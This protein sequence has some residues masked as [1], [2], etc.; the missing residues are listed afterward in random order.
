MKIHLCLRIVIVAF[1]LALAPLVS[2]ADTFFSDNFSN[3]STVNQPYFA[4]TTNSASYQTAGG[5]NLGAYSIS[6]G[7][8]SYSLT[9]NGSVL[10]EVMGMFAGTTTP[11]VLATNGDNI[12]LTVVFT[13]AQNIIGPTNSTSSTLNIGLY[14]TGTNTP[15]QGNTILNIDVKSGG[16][17]FW[18]GY[19]T[20]IFQSSGS[21]GIYTRAA[22]IVGAAAQ[23]Q[24]LLFNNAS[25]SQA[26]NNPTG[27][28]VGTTTGGTILTNGQVYTETLSIMLNAAN[29]YGVTNT[30]YA[31]AGT[32]GTVLFTQGKT[33][34]GS[35][36]VTGGFNAM[37]IGWRN[38]ATAAQ[39]ST[40]DIHSITVTGQGSQ[41]NGPPLITSQP[42]SATVATNGTCPFMVT[43]IGLSPTYQWHRNGAILTDGGNISGATSSTLAISS[44]GPADVFSGANGY[45][46]TISGLGGFSTNSVT[47]SLTLRAG[48]NLIWTAAN[49]AVWDVNTTASWQDPNSVQ[50]TFNYGDSVLFDDTGSDKNLNLNGN[51]LSASSVTVNSSSFY[52]WAAASTGGYA[53]PGKLIISGSG[54]FAIYNANSYTGGTII[55]NASA[56][57]YLE[58]LAGVG[59]GPVTFAQAGSKME[60]VPVSSANS[61]INGDV[62]VS[63]DGLI[64]LDAT[65]AYALAIYGNLAGTAGKTLTVTPQNDGT[66]NRFRVY[67]TNTV[68]NANLV[69]N[70]T[71]TLQANYYGL[72]LAPYNSSGLQFYN[73]I[74][75]GNGGF[76]MRGNT[77]VLTGQNT[78]T[79]G[80]TPTTGT[81]AIGADSIGSVSGPIG[82]GPLFVAPEVPNATGSGSILAWGGAHTITN[83]IQYPSATNNQTL[84]ISGTNALTFSGPI[85]LNGND[86]TGTFFNRTFQVTNTALT[87]F[88]GVISDN[89]SGFGLTKTSTGILALNNNE[90]Y[91]G[92]TTNSG[93]GTLQVNGSLNAASA[94]VVTNATLAGIGTI[95]GPVTITNGV[96]AP[97][98][99]AIG[100]LTFNSNLSLNGN[101]FFKLNRSLSPAQS[102][103]IAFVNGTLSSTGNGTLTVTNLGS[104]LA[105]GNKFKLFNTSVTGG[106]TLNVIGGGAVWNNNLGGDGSISVLTTNLKPVLTTSVILSKTNLIS[107]GTNGPAG[108]TYMVLTSTN[109]ALPLANWTPSYTNVFA[110]G[111]NFSVT[112][113]IATNVPNKF[114]LL[115]VVQP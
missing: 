22:Q 44:A 46:C 101:L 54:G 95:N 3:G 38:T 10:G 20:R 111:G 13:N 100:T 40:M 74:I 29:Q 51:Y 2:S 97:G 5:V 68:Y 82:T 31:G 9:N 58:N 109:L 60:V 99:T 80:T 23:N 77:A 28:L 35:T 107:S 39:I 25:S 91:T 105:T 114:Y 104:P 19:Y 76:V 108:Y 92:P 52:Q 89:G 24:D 42:V 79:G 86:A 63:D 15:N 55:S 75:S 62:I 41:P 49:G 56:I 71:S 18:V 1:V 36:Y 66:T 106:G 88:S 87:T 6:P 73:G 84:I 7:K 33:A 85:T 57:L 8:L 34:S 48:T 72:T 78:Y 90:T 64:Q 67:G 50:T 65:G 47:N 61:G 70:G 45:Y 94:V 83:S 98:T 96:L 12:N 11:I 69:L 102:N 115:K 30:L 17:Q 43:V 103:D 93:G 32:G 53:G 4:A 81:I 110:V 21:S 112:N 37:A 14:Y 26:F 16:S 113:L 27:T 59:N